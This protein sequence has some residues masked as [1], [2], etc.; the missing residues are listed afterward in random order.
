MPVPTTTECT[1]RREPSPRELDYA[2]G[3]QQI[4]LDH[5]GVGI[6]QVRERRIMRCNQRFAQIFGRTQAAQ[7]HGLLTRSLYDDETA[8]HALVAAAYPV[9]AQAQPYKTELRLK[10]HD[11]SLFWAHL[12]GTLVDP[13]DSARGAVWIVDDIDTQKQAEAA[14]QAVRDE[15]ELILDSAMVGIAFLRHRRVTL[16]NRAF[17]EIFGH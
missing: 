5:I 10:R 8:F 2:L 4:V 15:R 1:P 14:L 9:M 11:G 6:A 13:A 17:E 3:D 12:T 16:C 7:M